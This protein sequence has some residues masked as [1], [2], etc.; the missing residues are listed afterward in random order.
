MAKVARDDVLQLVP[1]LSELQ[2]LEVCDSE[3]LKLTKTKKDRKSALGNLLI[4][5]V[6]SEDIE[7]SEDE[8][9]AVFQ[10]LSTQMRELISEDDDEDA[11][12]QEKNEKEKQL[13]LQTQAEIEI[14]EAKL[15]DLSEQLKSA[16]SNVKSDVGYTG[17]D[18]FDGHGGGLGGLAFGKSPEVNFESIIEKMVDKRLKSISI[19]SGEKESSATSS[20][21]M[22]SGTSGGLF[23]RRENE[24]STVER[25]VKREAKGE[26]T[27]TTTDIHKL[28]LREFK[29]SNGIV[30]VEGSLDYSDLLMQMKEGLSSGYSKKEVMSGV[31]R[32]T[33]PGTELRKYLVRHPNMTYED[34]KQTLREFYNV[35]ESQSIMDEMR[36][37]VQ[38]EDQPLLKYV[39]SMCALRDE[40]FEVS[41]SEECPPGE[42]LVK[43]R[44]VDS[45]LSGLRIPTVRLEMQALLK[46]ELSDPKLFNEI[47]Q[48]TKR[49]NDNEKKVGVE[50][51][52]ADVKSVD[53]G[54]KQ[55]TRKQQDDE[56]REETAAKLT[57]LTTQVSKLEAIINKV[58]VGEFQPKMSDSALEEKMT[59]LLGTVQHLTAQ[60]QEYQQSGGRGGNRAPSKFK[61]KK[62][63]DCERDRKF[64]RHCWKC[65]QEGHKSSEC[66]EN[67]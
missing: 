35:R 5:Y 46:Q 13:L 23:G 16:I 51:K 3:N 41:S 8:G 12:R 7:E 1:K 29:I 10:K 34:F 47:N 33:K 9:L 50:T 32:A 39:M 53:V 58:A 55:R 11:T 66:S 40:V 56:W 37:M 25:E 15:S 63:D 19:P 60:M 67:S 28:K 30:G 22:S 17:A 6:S 2:L 62:C 38:G 26:S 44:F 61:F 59:S 27:T 65:K 52:S 20:G 18:D 48:I 54:K 64:C 21:G 36:D 24:T 43:K 14:N 31:I 4:R 42:A 45:C 57:T 49:V